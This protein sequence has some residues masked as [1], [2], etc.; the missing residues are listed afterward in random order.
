MT[1]E[2]KHFIRYSFSFK[3]KVV[4]EIEEEGLSIMEAKRRYGIKGGGTIQYWLAQFGKNHLLNKVVRIEMKDEKDRI[5]ERE[6]EVTRL[7]LALADTVLTK[8]ILQTVIQLAD[9]HYGADLK[10]NFG[11]QRSKVFKGKDT[12]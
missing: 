10:K 4:R 8:D 6:A 11:S 2:T 7:R 5:K 9:D 3:Q 1:K 12:P